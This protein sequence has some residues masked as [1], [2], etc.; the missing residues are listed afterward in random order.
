MSWRY[1]HRWLSHRMT[2]NQQ[3]VKDPIYFQLNGLLRDLI[4]TGQFRKGDQFLT[5]REIATRFGISRATANKALSSL[6]AEGIVSFK[7]GV[8]TFVQSDLLDYDLRTL[9]SFTEK[10]RAAGRVPSTRVL[11]FSTAIAGNMPAEIVE[12]LKLLS[13]EQAYYLERLRLAD[14]APVI[15]ERRYI[16][17][18]HCP[19]LSR[20]AIEGSLYEVLTEQFHLDITGADETIRA[21]LITGAH[22]DALK[23]PQ[24]SAGL[25]VEAVGFANGSDPVW[26]EQTLYRGDAYEFRNHLGPIRSGR[27]ASGALIEKTTKNKP[28]KEKL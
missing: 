15:L 18:R 16:A 28:T 9:Q 21:V 12:A 5:E 20:A 27:P 7:K 26:H 14:K 19:N 4:R 17:A 23:V 2:M 8:G 11:A 10:A 3:L 13:N 22:A 6:V 25:L 1:E 24:N